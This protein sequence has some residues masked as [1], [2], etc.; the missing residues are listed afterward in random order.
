MRN[1]K[2]EIGRTK[3]RNKGNKEQIKNEDEKQTNKKK[4]KV[5]QNVILKSVIHI[6]MR[7]PKCV[8]SLAPFLQRS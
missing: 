6:Y 5:A 8:R 3:Q 1:R 2:E 4:E 7:S